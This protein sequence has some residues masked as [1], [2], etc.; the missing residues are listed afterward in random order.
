MQ[1][2][3]LGEQPNSQA[4]IFGCASVREYTLTA[5]NMIGNGE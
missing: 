4:Q 3:S 1:A 2:S 5:M